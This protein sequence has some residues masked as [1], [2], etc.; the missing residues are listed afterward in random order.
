MT[1]SIEL[2]SFLIMTLSGSIGAFFLKKGTSKL[3]GEKLF[4]IIFIREIYIGGFLYLLGAAVNIYL[5]RFIP[6]SIVY[7]MTSLSYVWT[8]IISYFLL[9][10]NITWNK[11]VSVLLII[12]GVTILN[13]P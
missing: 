8:M 12:L 13:I 7:T 4:H 9:K 10:E 3:V 5:L 1:L 6:Y 11:I 2:L